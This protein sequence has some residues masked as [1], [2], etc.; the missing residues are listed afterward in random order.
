MNQNK[1]KN[2]I[3]SVVYMKDGDPQTVDFIRTLYGVLNP[4]FSHYEIICVNDG[5]EEKAM[6][7]IRALAGTLPGAVLSVVNM[8]FPQGLELSMSAGVELAI[9]DFVYEFDSACLDYEPGLILDAYHRSLSGFDIVSASPDQTHSVSSKL[10]YGVYNRFS[11][12]PYRI[13]TERFRI[14]SRRAINRVRSMSV[15]LPYRKATYAS[16]GLKL[17]T[18]FYPP[19]KNA[20]LSSGASGSKSDVAVDSLMLFTNIAYKASLLMTGLMMGISLFSI[21]YTVVTFLA[22]Q[23][24]AGWTTTMLFLSVVFFGVFGL[25]AIVIKYLSILTNLV[26]KKQKYIIHS[27]EKLTK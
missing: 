20:R 3:S 7:P 25:L 10:F 4:V 16:C 17:D 27:I 1:E 2:F 19:L 6:E 22:H 11:G 5:A 13:K 23:P 21:V 8:S 9:G 26:F 18:L 15:T 12:N 14:L 24:V